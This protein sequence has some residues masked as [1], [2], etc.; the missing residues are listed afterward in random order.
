[1]FEGP[2]DIVLVLIKAFILVETPNRLMN[3]KPFTMVMM[4]L[5]KD[6]H[7]DFLHRCM[8]VSWLDSINQ[9]ISLQMWRTF[10]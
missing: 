8:L 1:M 2:H 5:S 6:G 10:Q 3:C 7:D 4:N 9:A